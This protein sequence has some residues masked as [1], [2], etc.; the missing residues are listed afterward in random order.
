MGKI[1]DLRELAGVGGGVGVGGS[2]WELVGSWWEF[3]G[4]RGVGGA[5]AA[6]VRWGMLS[7]G[8]VAVCRECAWGNV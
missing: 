1:A 5:K 6:G 2:W 8:C 3:V 7:G 4:A